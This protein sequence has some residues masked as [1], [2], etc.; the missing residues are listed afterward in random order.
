VSRW[1]RCSARVEEAEEIVV[2][3]LLADVP[4]CSAGLP[5]KKIF[6]E[7]EHNLPEKEE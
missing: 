7:S 5:L 1:H 4:T 6:S 3:F 2:F